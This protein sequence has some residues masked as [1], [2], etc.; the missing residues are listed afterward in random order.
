MLRPIMH[1]DVVQK[2]I[3]MVENPDV[4][5]DVLIS[6][7]KY[8]EGHFRYIADLLRAVQETVASNQTTDVD[9]TT[10]QLP[11]ITP[12][13][14]GEARSSAHDSDNESQLDD[15]SSIHSMDIVKSINFGSENTASTS[16]L[17]A[18]GEA[19]VNAQLKNGQN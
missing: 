4:V 7:I 17:P 14:E 8:G 18:A 9:E 2:A 1:T 13:V 6:R 15:T 12:Y 11:T 10:P 5:R 19:A 16:E 3:H